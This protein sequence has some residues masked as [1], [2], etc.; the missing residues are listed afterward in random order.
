MTD[1]SV[2]TAQVEGASGI[3]YPALK[4]EVKRLPQ[5]YQAAAPPGG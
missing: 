5:S 1:K 2:A 4:K 3:S